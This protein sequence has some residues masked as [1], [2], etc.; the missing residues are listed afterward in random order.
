MSVI[1]PACK[2]CV[3]NKVQMGM[4][5]IRSVQFKVFGKLCP[6]ESRFTE[7]PAKKEENQLVPEIEIDQ[8]TVE[9]LKKS[10]EIVGYLGDVIKDQQGNILSGRHRKLA[11]PK[12]P[13]KEVTVTD[14][15]QREL[16]VLHFNVQRIV[17]KEETQRRLVKIA[18]LVESTGVPINQ[19][20]GEVCRLVPYTEQYVRELLPEKYKMVSK[21]RDFAKLVSQTRESKDI[22]QPGPLP[23]SVNGVLKRKFDVW[24]IASVDLK[25]PFGDPDYPGC[26]PGD[27]VGNVLLWFLPEGGKVVDPM[28]GGGVTEDVCHALGDKYQPLLYDNK[29][30][31]SYN[32]RD[33]IRFND[34]EQ[35]S[36]P[37]KA[38]GADLIFADPP[39]GPLKEYGA[40]PEKLYSILKG[41][42][43][44]SLEALKPNGIV[45]IL[46]QN[47]Y[48]DGEC[49][50]KFI[51]L[52]RRTA[53]IF[54]NY[55]FKQVFEGTVPLHGKV[56][57]SEEHMTHIDRR[58]MIFQK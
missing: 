54:E 58:L 24:N 5:R 9:K 49:L 47:Y 10:K 31:K 22:R 20:C 11:D 39:Y 43:K 50:G 38:H 2:N 45:A 6:K 21:R 42:A 4:C 36:L 15:L 52:V 53:E 40:E 16:M 37:E 14:P 26:I 28:A 46:M 12:W 33:S 3:K 27:I 19:V 51:P 32:Y 29:S 30:L 41:L 55:G 23:H 8:E 25:K 7:E 34:I 48:T 18:Q 44:A 56:A 57:R 1:P 35:G 13:E 17:P